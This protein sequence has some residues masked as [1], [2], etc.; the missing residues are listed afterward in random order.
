VISAAETKT[1]NAGSTFLAFLLW[2]ATLYSVPQYSFA[3]VLLWCA[4][5]RGT[6]ENLNRTDLAFLTII[7]SA[8][9]CNFIYGL[10]FNPNS[11]DQRSP[12]FLA[13]GAT[14]LIARSLNRDVLR[15]CIAFICLEAMFVYLEFAL[16]INTIFTSSP[17]Y[18]SGLSYAFLYFSRPFGLSDS[19]SIIGY[20]LLL[21]I[22]LAD[23]IELSVRPR[24]W[25]NLIVYPAFVLVFNRTAIVALAAYYL[26][27]WVRRAFARGINLVAIAFAAASVTVLLVMPSAI[28]AIAWSQFNRDKD[29]I[30][31]SYR[32]VIWGDFGRFI[33][34]H[35][36]LGNGS[37]KYFAWISDYGSFE[38]AH[39]S[40]LELIASNGLLIASLYFCWFALRL[41]RRNI[42]FAAPIMIYSLSQYGFFWG[43]SFVDIIFCQIVLFGLGAQAGCEVQRIGIMGTARR[44]S[45]A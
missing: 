18:R 31:L 41:T 29:E 8:S 11:G 42:I 19:Q 17:E 9:L 38:H 10:V 4:L 13:Y 43:I 34:S 37:S 1:T 5:T 26:I 44:H 35:P 24:F 21:A 7:V 14:Y 33:A 12:Y 22:I 45:V 36:L 3:V 23:Y 15:A 20:K 30:D 39:N 25:V 27:K 40:Y 16:R 32:D 2:F 6:F 28:S